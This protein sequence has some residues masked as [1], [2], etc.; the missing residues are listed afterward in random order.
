MFDTNRETRKYRYRWFAHNNRKSLSNA[1]LPRRAGIEPY[2]GLL[3]LRLFVRSKKTKSKVISGIGH[4]T[5]A[6]S[7]ASAT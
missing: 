7:R 1:N 6:A 4:G 2:L 5:V 3:S